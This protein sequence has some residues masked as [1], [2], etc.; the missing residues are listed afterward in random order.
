[1]QRRASANTAKRFSP[2][3]VYGDR[4]SARLKV[5]ERF[6][7][8]S[9]VQIRQR[10]EQAKAPDKDSPRAVVNAQ[11]CWTLTRRSW[12]PNAP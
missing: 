12:M 9:S 8:F 1:M 6:G 3:G 4:S 2:T 7:L 11:S 10:D 5:D